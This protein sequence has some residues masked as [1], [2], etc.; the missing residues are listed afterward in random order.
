MGPDAGTG[1]LEGS[2]KVSADHYNALTRAQAAGHGG[3]RPTHA[4]IDNPCNSHRSQAALRNGCRRDSSVTLYDVDT[5]PIATFTGRTI[6]VSEQR[7]FNVRGDDGVTH[8]YWETWQSRHDGLLRVTDLYPGQHLT[9]HT[10][11]RGYWRDAGG[12]SHLNGRGGCRLGTPVKMQAVSMSGRGYRSSAG[13]Y[14]TFAPYTNPD[15]AVI[16]RHRERRPGG[17]YGPWIPHHVA[18]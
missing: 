1:T 4:D 5:H 7:R 10:R 2:G 9:E 14:I 12:H 15:A 8:T 13:T 17:S 11:Y 6:N 16:W 3:A 18:R